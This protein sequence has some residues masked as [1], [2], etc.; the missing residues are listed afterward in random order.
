[1]TLSG[2]LGTWWEGSWAGLQLP[3]IGWRV[4]VYPLAVYESE[5][6]DWADIPDAVLCV[7]A[8]HDGGRKTCMWSKDGYPPPPPFTGGVKL[9]FQVGELNSPEWFDTVKRIRDA[10]GLS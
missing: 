2:P 4:W 5:D 1:M 9:G 3:V 8:L 10:E 7:V 6:S